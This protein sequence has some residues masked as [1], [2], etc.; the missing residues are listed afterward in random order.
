MLA[1]LGER[2]SP[3]LEDHRKIIEQVVATHKGII[4][5]TEGDATFAVF[6]LATGAVAAAVEVQR[7]LINHPWPDSNS[8]VNVRIGLHTGEVQVV[9]GNYVGM[10]V[11]QASRICSVGHGKQI[12]ISS[13]TRDLVRGVLPQ[14]VALR[15]L[16][17]FRLK[18]LAGEEELFQAEHCDLPADFPAPRTV[19]VAPNNLPVQLT[20]FV[21]RRTEKAQIQS[22]LSTSRMLTLLGPGGAGKTRLALAVASES[23]HE[24]PAGVWIA[25]LSSVEDPNLVPSSIAR[26]VGGAN[27]AGLSAVDRSEPGP[28]SATGTGGTSESGVESNDP[29]DRLIDNLSGKKLLLLLDNCEHLIEACA[30]AV[31]K[32]LTG[33]VGLTIVA[34]SRERLG[35]SGEVVVQVAP[36]SLDRSEDGQTGDAVDMFVERAQAHL[37]GFELTADTKSYVM[38]ICTMLDGL[39]LAIELAAS[40]V[41]GLSVQQ[42][43]EKLRVDRFRLLTKGSRTVDARQQTLWSSIEWSYRLLSEA[44]QT[45]LARLAIF[46]SSFD[47]EAAE[48]VCSGDGL[49]PAET[50]EM[51]STL[52]DKSFVVFRPDKSGSRYRL[53]ETIRAYALS[54]LCAATPVV[55]EPASLTVRLKQEGDYWSLEREGNVF[56]LRGAKGLDYLS[57]LLS[58]PGREFHV[59]DLTGSAASDAGEHLDPEARRAY[60]RRLGELVEEIEEAQTFSDSAKAEKLGDEKRALE[61]EISRAFGLGGRSR[62]AG[63]SAERAR[64][65]VTKA[66]RSAIDKVGRLDEDLGKHLSEAV[67]T[68]LYASYKPTSGPVWEVQPTP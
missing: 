53:L 40:H 57:L 67:N 14:G 49:D 59:L 8:K 12:L 3:L 28:S 61:A 48:N 55:S 10:A 19:E 34:T 42:I 50:Y 58:E 1:A 52:V 23:A 13:T 36:L 11:H 22:A 18:D 6:E 51:L 41:R 39:P 5:G 26:A 32:L 9:S 27:V 35:L 65:S 31:Q 45:L 56:R 47:L 38:E 15:R 44:E 21:G 46:T 30:V 66:L 62:L 60:A 43:A 4:V 20:N 2:W 25:D 33:C 37:A 24:Y 17:S 64:T 16:G 63:D 29:L 54:C 68:G 7:Q